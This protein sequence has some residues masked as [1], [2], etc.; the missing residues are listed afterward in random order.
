[1][2]FLIVEYR[3][4]AVGISTADRWEF[5]AVDVDMNVLFLPT[6]SMNTLWED[7]YL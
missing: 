1:M 3:R 4:T 2:K 7:K 5:E 6:I